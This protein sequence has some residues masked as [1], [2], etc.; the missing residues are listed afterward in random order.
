MRKQQEMDMGDR[1]N[2]DTKGTEEDTGL[3]GSGGG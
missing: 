2:R 3:E 1:R